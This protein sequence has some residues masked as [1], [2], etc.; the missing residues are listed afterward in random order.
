MRQQRKRQRQ[1]QQRKRQPPRAK[2]PQKKVPS[3]KAAQMPPKAEKRRKVDNLSGEPP[4]IGGT[5]V[6]FEKARVWKR[7]T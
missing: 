6:F 3:K 4:R 5:V 1:R 2:P 7:R